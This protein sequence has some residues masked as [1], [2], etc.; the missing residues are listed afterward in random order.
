MVHAFSEIS[1]A[2]G[3]SGELAMVDSAMPPVTLKR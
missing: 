2:A 1:T 3:F